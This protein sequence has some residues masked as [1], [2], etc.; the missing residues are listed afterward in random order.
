MTGGD[1]GSVFSS[2]DG[3]TWTSRISGTDQEL[4]DVIYIK[5]KFI[6]FGYAGVII[7]SSDGITWT[8]Q[9]SGTSEYIRRLTND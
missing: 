1:N 4:N 3:I 8:S 2:T 6:F 7:T 9:D 5:D